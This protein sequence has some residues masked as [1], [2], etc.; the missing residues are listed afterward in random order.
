MPFGRKA[1]DNLLLT[2]TQ[3][4]KRPEAAWKGICRGI[5]ASV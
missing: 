3:L 5:Q 1:H 2:D 4:K